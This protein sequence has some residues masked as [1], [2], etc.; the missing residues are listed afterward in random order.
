[1]KLTV[2]ICTHNRSASLR[3]LLESLCSVVP[4]AAS[5]WEVLVVANACTDDT[6]AVAESFRARLP[7]RVEP[8]TRPGLS[9]ARNRA[10]RVATGD[11]ILWTDD[12]ARVESGW[13]AAY[14]EAFRA[15]PRAA[16]WGGTIRADFEGGDPAWLR[17][18]WDHLHT[19]FAVREAR[20]PGRVIDGRDGEFPYGCN[21]AVR[22][23]DLPSSP[24]DEE[25]GRH[26]GLPLRGGE[27]IALFHRLLAAGRHGRWVPEAVVHHRIG[28]ERQ[29]LRYVRTYYQGQGLTMGATPWDGP[30][31]S[32]TRLIGRA[33]RRECAARLARWR[34]DA[35]GWLI[36]MHRAAWTRGAIGARLRSPR[37]PVQ[38]T[39]SAER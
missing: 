27:E 19:A 33:I 18:A 24:F 28:P 30:S 2:A 3:L 15:D 22:Q 21:F 37:D 32:L 31:Q 35:R 25:L 23:R 14:A 11:F 1:M 29:T 20:E 16:F 7:L 13:L 12:D 26:P 34:G 5:E 36:E 8:E 38:E 9:A 17:P 39:R 6:V 10:V 4:P